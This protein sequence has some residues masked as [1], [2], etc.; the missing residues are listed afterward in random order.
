MSDKRVDSNSNE[1][2][3]RK[4]ETVA[5]ICFCFLYDLCSWMANAVG[6]VPNSVRSYGLNSLRELGTAKERMAYYVNADLLST[7]EEALEPFFEAG[8]RLA[9]EFG[10]VISMDI[11]GLA[12]GGPVVVTLVFK[13]SSA[14]I[15]SNEVRALFQPQ[16]W[17]M[18]L[19]LRPD[20]ER[21]ETC[22]LRQEAMA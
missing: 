10:D 6:P 2:L 14:V 19:F 1:E 7:Y 12:E 4:L 22:T 8:L 9:P 13:D 18:K 16:P 15:D 3:G 17:V 21:V 20:L 5:V 11:E